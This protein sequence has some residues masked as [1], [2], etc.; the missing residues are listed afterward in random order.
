MRWKKILIAAVVIFA[1]LI[2]AIYVFLAFYDFNRFKPL[3]AQTL[4]DATGRELTITG[5][6]EIDLGIRPT[7]VVED[8]SFQNAVWST[9]PDLARVKRLEVQLAVWPLISGK[10]DFTHL[11]LIEPNVIVEFDSAGTSN[12]AFDTNENGQADSEIQ[13]PPLI[14]SDVLIKKGLFTYKDARSDFEFS[15]LIDHLKA[16]IPGFDKSLGLD[17]KGTFNDIPFTLKGAVGPIWAWVAPGYPLLADLRIGAGGATAHVKGEIGDPKNLNDIALTVAAEGASVADVAKLAGVA[18]VQELGAFKV[19]AGLAD[20]DGKLGIGGLDVQIGTEALAAISISGTVK[21]LLAQRGLDLDFAVRGNDAANLVKF[22][23]PPLLSRQA[24][25]V[26]G[27]ILDSQIDRYAV[28]D[29]K[30][31]LG[32]DEISGRLDLNLA[33]TPPNLTADLTSQEFVLGPLSWRANLPGQPIN[34]PLRNWN[35][36]SATQILSRSS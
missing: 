15:I 19:K 34:W 35:C 16:A 1:V 13:P 9:R 28:D 8:V 31:A 23:L 27:R 11:V 2:T 3:I 12:F 7:L 24:F 22:G 17:F 5:D 33:D 18:G 29:L 14:F 26:S 32:Q 4:K 20:S 21:D 36:L 30:V 6:I 10:F 25:S